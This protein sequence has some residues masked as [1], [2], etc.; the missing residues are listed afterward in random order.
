MSVEKAILEGIVGDLNGLYR[1][2][3]AFFLVEDL[4]YGPKDDSI[5]AGK[6]QAVT[7]KVQSFGKW[8]E[9]CRIYVSGKNL[10]VIRR[11][12]SVWETI[13]TFDIDNPESLPNAYGVVRAIIQAS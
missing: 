11:F 6:T 1:K 13:S 4:A 8:K 5:I 7:G 10:V 2:Y 9:L 3:N 12:D